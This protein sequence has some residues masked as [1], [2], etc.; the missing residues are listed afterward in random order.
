[1]TQAVR[2]DA[3]SSIR[4]YI[5]K[6]VSDT[7]IDG[8]LLLMLCCYHDYLIYVFLLYLS[9]IILCLPIMIVYIII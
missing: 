5:D 9:I 8:E 4:F 7:N 1:M 2:K 3:I 6:I